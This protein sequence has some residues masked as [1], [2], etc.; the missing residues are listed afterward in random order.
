MEQQSSTVLQKLIR[1]LDLQQ[2]DRDLFLGDPGR[3][4]GRLYGGLVAAMSVVASN[5][6]V[7]DESLVH[8]LHAY[9]IRPGRHG[10][11]I[12]FTV[13]EIRDGRTY[14]TRRVVAHQSGEGIFSL[15][16]SYTRPEDGLSH[17]DPMPDAPAPEGLED[18]DR[19]RPDRADEPRRSI[20]GPIEMRACAPDPV[21]KA[22][23]PAPFHQVWI[24]PRGELP[25]GPNFHAAM[26]TFASDR[27]MISTVSRWHGLPSNRASQASLDHTIWFHRPPR[28][29]DWILYTTTSHAAHNGRALIFGTMYHRNGELAASVAQEGLFRA[30]LPG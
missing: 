28:F 16:A 21:T 1:R 7:P 17:Q 20:D 2:L 24:K 5:R 19:V 23:A 14:T 27:G 10:V 9:F 6:T 4:E 30:R 22:D 13:H 18:W 11:P 25:A 3:G 26:I 12:Q 8:S 15:E 29:D